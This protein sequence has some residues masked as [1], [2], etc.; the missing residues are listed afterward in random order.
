[1]LV[2][3]FGRFAMPWMNTDSRLREE[4]DRPFDAGRPQISARGIAIVVGEADSGDELH[5]GQM[6]VQGHQ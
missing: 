1:M 5:L 4:S 2:I 3:V 6:L